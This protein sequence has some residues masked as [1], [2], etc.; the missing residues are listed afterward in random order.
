MGTGDKKTRRGKIIMG[1]DGR[2]RPKRGAFKIKPKPVKTET[3][4]NS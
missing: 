3:V 1:S 4:N 2:F